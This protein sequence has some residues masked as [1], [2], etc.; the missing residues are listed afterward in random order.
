MKHFYLRH[1]IHATL[2]TS[3]IFAGVKSSAQCPGGYVPSGIA[4][5]TTINFTDGNHSSVIKFPKFDGTTGMVTCARLSMTI[6]STLNFMY[7]ENRDN[8]P[9]TAGVNFTRTDAISGPGLSSPMTNSETNGFGPY[10]LSPRDATPNTGPDYIGVGP[11]TIFNTTKTITITDI[12]DLSQFYG[13]PGDSLVYNYTAN[14]SSAISTTGNWF[15]GV[16]AS[17]SI[18]YRIEFCYCPAVSLPLNVY[19]F[20]VNKTSANKAEL[21]W[22]GTDDPGMDF[23][24]EVEVSRNAYDYTRVGILEKND[25]I[26]GNFKMNFSALHGETG[27]YHFRVKQ[28]YANGYVRFSNTRQVVL[29][30]FEKNSFSIYPNPSNGI[31]GIKFDNI[32]AEE[33]VIQIF[34]TQGQKVLTKEIVVNGPSYVQLGNL[35]KGAYWVRVISK[36]D[37][38][39]SVQQLITK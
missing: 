23:Y 32:S 10:N 26:S 16:D 33:F 28:V 39:S 8:F 1:F 21:K 17:G 9:N 20:N 38:A 2:L 31:V 6:S 37:R 36:K 4:F 18:H 35:T 27:V 24:Y 13:P 19:S 25:N 3:G 7:F 15:G 5:D 12:S 30:S 14:G 11:E 34:N 22:S 29:E